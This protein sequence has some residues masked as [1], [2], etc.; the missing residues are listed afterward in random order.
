MLKYTPS[1]LMTFTLP[2]DLFSSTI[3]N[4]MSCFCCG[5][6]IILMLYCVSWLASLTQKKSFPVS[7]LFFRVGMHIII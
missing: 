1:S 2:L 4:V 3:F 5:S 7:G 6:L